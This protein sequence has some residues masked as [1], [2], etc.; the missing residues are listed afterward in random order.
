MGFCAELC[1]P[2]FQQSCWHCKVARQLVARLQ[3]DTTPSQ[4]I[5]PHITTPNE[6]RI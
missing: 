6:T 4:D 2:D 5:V 3:E 1:L